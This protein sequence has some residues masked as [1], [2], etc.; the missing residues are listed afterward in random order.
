[1]PTKIS[2]DWTNCLSV[3]ANFR[4]SPAFCEYILIDGGHVFGSCSFIIEMCVLEVATAVLYSYYNVV[5]SHLLPTFFLS[6]DKGS[7]AA[8]L[9]QIDGSIEMSIGITFLVLRTIIFITAHTH[10]FTLLST[11]Y[12]SHQ[13]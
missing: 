11:I 2:D 4:L 5:A 10:P 9:L 8:Y 3:M 6:K 12:L 1:M 13:R 7:N